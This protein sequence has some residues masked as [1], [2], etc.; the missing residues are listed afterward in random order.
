MS[1]KQ[2]LRIAEL[3][4]AARLV[5]NEVADQRTDRLRTFAEEAKALGVW[6]PSLQAVVSAQLHAIRHLRDALVGLKGGE[7][8]PEKQE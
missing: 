7:G 6:T 3:Q 5:V 4:E 1:G 2:P 8:K